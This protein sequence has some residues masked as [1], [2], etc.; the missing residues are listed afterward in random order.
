MPPT[1]I[2]RHCKAQ[3]NDTKIQKQSQS[4]VSDDKHPSSSRENEETMRKGQTATDLSKASARQN[5]ELRRFAWAN[6]NEH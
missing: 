6:H 5:L 1:H 3:G 2:R 4:K